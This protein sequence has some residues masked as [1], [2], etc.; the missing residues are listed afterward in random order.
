MSILFNKHIAKVIADVAVFL[1]FTDD[2]LLNQD[3]AIEAMEQ[4]AAELQ[5][6]REEEKVSLS[7]AF[8]EISNEYLD[9]ICKEFVKNLSYSFGIND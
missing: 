9:P 6:M 4:M 2:D 8:E 1:E 5:L 3:L 7:L